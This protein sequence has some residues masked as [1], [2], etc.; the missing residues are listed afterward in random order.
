MNVAGPDAMSNFSERRSGV[1]QRMEVVT[2]RQDAPVLPLSP[3]ASTA[4]ED[5]IQIRDIAGLGPVKAEIST[6]PFANADGEIYQGASVGKRNIVLSLGLNPDWPGY[7]LGQ[8]TVAELRQKLYTYFLPKQ[9]VK[10]RFFIDHLLSTPSVA[11]EGYVESMEPSIF[12]K[13]PEVQISIICPRPD[14]IDT[15]AVFHNGNVSDLNGEVVEFEFPYIGTVDT[16]F[17]VL[18]TNSALDAPDYTGKLYI[19]NKAPTLQRF[20]IDPVTLIHDSKEFR[21]S[22]I[23]SA[24]RAQNVMPDGSV[25]NLLS[26][27]TT[28]SKWPV[29]RPGTNLFS[30]GADDPET[31]P[32]GLRDMVWKL[33]Y[34]AHY[35]GL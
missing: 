2:S 25:L 9:W 14:F 31:S 16:G 7:N 27:V 26:H 1:I 35:G 21:L 23:K 20:A 10:L 18:V 17:E 13:D 29:L 22:T 33:A 4:N 6:T 24:K 32:D 15:Q 8:Q 11:I 28:V 5:P 34:F 30:V 19:S 12:S 3:Y